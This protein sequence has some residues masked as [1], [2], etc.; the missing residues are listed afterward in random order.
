MTDVLEL[1]IDRVAKLP[2]AVQDEIVRSVFEIEGVT[3]ASTGWTTMSGHTF[4]RL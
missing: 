4:L 3:M 1:L 2:M